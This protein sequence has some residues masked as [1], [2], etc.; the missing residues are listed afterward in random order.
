MLYFS[1]CLLEKH[2]RPDTAIV[3]SR[4]ASQNIPGVVVDDGLD[5]A[6]CS[7]LKFYDANIDMPELVRSAGSDT[8]L[9]LSW[10]YTFQRTP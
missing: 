5:K 7:V 6:L 4:S 1:E 3:F 8:Y 9:G 2:F 10:I